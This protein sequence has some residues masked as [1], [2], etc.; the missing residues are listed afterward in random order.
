[1]KLNF[2]LSFTLFTLF[3]TAN[4]VSAHGFVYKV[5]IDGQSYTGNTPNA[6]PNPSI[7]RQIND[8]GPVKGATNPEV[9]CGHDA[10]LAQLVAD[11]NPGSVMTFDWRGGDLSFVS[12]RP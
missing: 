2:F 12:V 8:V 5:T 10:Q 4:H 6:D 1:M 3:L 7:T 9:N 11:A